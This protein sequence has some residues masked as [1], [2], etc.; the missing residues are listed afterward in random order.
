MTTVV[1]KFNEFVCSP[2]DAI[3]S[4]YNALYIFLTA[5]AALFK[6]YSQE[7]SIIILKLI[8]YYKIKFI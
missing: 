2:P 6:I 3:V 1:N 7:S 8:N 4:G 5:F